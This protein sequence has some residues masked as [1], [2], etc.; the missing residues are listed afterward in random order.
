[1]RPFRL[2]LLLVFFVV[3]PIFLTCLSLRP[4]GENAADPLSTRN[5]SPGGLR[6]LFSFHTPSSLFPPSAIISLTYDNSTFFL[7]RPAAFGPSL[8]AKGLTGQLWVG[9]GF[10][11]E[12]VD[13]DGDI[14]VTGWEL[15]CSDVPDW[16]EPQR[17]HAPKG[18]QQLKARGKVTSNDAADSAAVD[19]V[20]DNLAR[21]DEDVQDPGRAEDTTFEEDDGTDDHL[22]HPLLDSNP[23][24]AARPGEPAN[25]DP[26]T[27]R[28][29]KSTHA[30]IQS[31]QESADIAGKIVML[32]RGGCG[33]LEKVKWTQ[34]RGGIALI[35]GDNQRGAALTIMYAKGDTSNITIPAIFTSYTSAQIL[36]SLVPPEE[37]EQ[38][39]KGLVSSRIG[40][41]V[42]NDIDD[43]PTFTTKTSAHLPKPTLSSAKGGK[44]VVGSDKGWKQHVFAKI[45]FGETENSEFHH[46]EDSRRP[47]SSG[48]INWVLV[49][50]W[51]EEDSKQKDAKGRGS[52]GTQVTTSTSVAAKATSMTRRPVNDDFII[53][54]QDWRDADLVAPKPLLKDLDAAAK[55]SSPAKAEELSS[56]TKILDPAQTGL[57]K[58]GSITPG[59]GEYETHRP[60]DSPSQKFGPAG[61]DANGGSAQSSSSFS[62]LKF[63]RSGTSLREQR[64]DHD[65]SKA[66]NGVGRKSA[67]HKSGNS[68]DNKDHEPQ[69]LWVTLT[70]ASVSTSPFFDTLLVLVV[71]PLITLSVVY[72]LLL[73]RS[74]I[75]RRR[76]RAPKSIVDRLPVRTYHITSTS[77][78][79]T[80]SQVSTPNQSSPASPLL[81]S[82]PQ[83]IHSRARPRSQTT[84]GVVTAGN[85]SSS[86][87]QS[88]SPPPLSLP[89]EKSGSKSNKRKRYTGR[90]VECVVCLEEYVDGESRVMSLPCG[91]EF[92]ADCIR[93]WLVNR[94]RTCPICKGDVVRSMAKNGTGMGNVTTDRAHALEGEENSESVQDRVAETRN[95]SPSAAIPVPAHGLSEPGLDDELLLDEDVERGPATAAD[96]VEATDADGL[97]ATRQPP[98][99]QSRTGRGAGWRNIFG[100]SLSALSGETLWRSTSRASTP[101]D[102]SR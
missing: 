41:K 62:W 79:T 100:S 5:H 68:A 84:T 76:W 43:G 56:L 102:R 59:S 16:S 7:A 19:R 74:R 88:L 6:A 30:D 96:A 49:E 28:S 46:A 54:V 4:A 60:E 40:A 31:L 55:E 24:R 17:M 52:D 85:G 53:G 58:G 70:P 71:S 91:H 90:Q 23:A 72:A 81:R 20:M 33:F 42:A 47:P 51:D 93:P 8:P 78:S 38:S 15:G 1:M 92:H 64:V 9:K 50:D 48:N 39:S 10:G 95:D 22:H 97:G 36:S 35:V 98:G 61:F 27:S 83:E 29:G 44:A 37:E 45:G 32:A 34:R 21:A 66:I 89:T 86:K 101:V 13:E 80:S 99:N 65:Q 2:L 82:V 75:R 57:L 3:V 87:D 77:S 94:R 18:A 67:N 63:W 73:L 25:H 26:S 69:G 12:L 14:Q 11:E